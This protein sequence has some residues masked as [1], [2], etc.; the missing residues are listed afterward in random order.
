MIFSSIEATQSPLLHLPLAL[1]MGFGGAFAIFVVFDKMFR[2][3]QSSSEARVA[4]LIGHSATV[5][6]SIPE[7]GMG[8]VAYVV[9]GSRYNVPAREETGQSVPTGAEVK[10]TRVVGGSFHVKKV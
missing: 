4:A 9:G 2:M 5:T 1:L 3:T 8:E 10:I 6:V 7:A